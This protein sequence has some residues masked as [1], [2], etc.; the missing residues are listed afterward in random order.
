MAFQIPVCHN[1]R[2]L[3]LYGCKVTKFT[4]HIAQ[5]T[6]NDELKAL[7]VLPVRIPDLHFCDF[8]A[9]VCCCQKNDHICWYTNICETE[10]RTPMRPHVMKQFLI[11]AL[12]AIQYTSTSSLGY[13]L[14]IASRIMRSCTSLWGENNSILF[15]S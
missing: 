10:K 5:L 1:H 14:L 7:N 12:Q 3:N 4:R 9:L 13:V 6:I 15:C 11:H 2:R 8:I